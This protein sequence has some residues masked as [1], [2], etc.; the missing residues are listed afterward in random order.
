LTTPKKTS[1]EVSAEKRF[2]L[3]DGTILSS[4]KELDNAFGKMDESVWKHHVTKDRNDFAN[5]VEGVFQEKK[6]GLAIRK[7]KTAKAAGKLVRSKVEGAKLW[8]FF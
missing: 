2:W 3:S 7:A 5:W 6:L 8:T 1:F 4:L